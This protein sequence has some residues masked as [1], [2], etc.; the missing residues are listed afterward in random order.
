M[1][2]VGPIPVFE[3]YRSSAFKGSAISYASQ[4]QC[5]Q[6][7]CGHRAAT[8]MRRSGAVYRAYCEECMDQAL[9]FGRRK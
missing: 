4:G 6:A 9:F 7:R 1:R 3:P 8:R 2:R 5:S